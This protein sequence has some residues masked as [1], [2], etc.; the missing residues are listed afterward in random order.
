MREVTFKDFGAVAKKR[1]HTAESLAERFR[2]KI[3]NPSEFFERVMT[4]RYHSADRSWVV[5]PYRS[6]LEFYNEEL[7]YFQDSNTK[8][9]QCACGCGLP[10]FDRK[11][12]AS[13]GCRQRVARKNVTDTQKGVRQAVDFVEAKV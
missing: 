9:R 4:C 13:P 6:V 8:H 2:G 3:E 11:K 5:I 12:W 7:H 10:V 1:G